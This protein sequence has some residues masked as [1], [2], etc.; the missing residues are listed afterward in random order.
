ML[1]AS[2]SVVPRP[3]TLSQTTTLHVKTMNGAAEQRTDDGG[4]PPAL[5]LAEERGFDLALRDLAEDLLLGEIGREAV[6]PAPRSAAWS[7]RPL[8]PLMTGRAI[9]RIRPRRPP[10]G[11]IHLGTT[12]PDQAFDICDLS[13]ANETSG[14]SLKY[15]AARGISTIDDG[16]SLRT[17][18]S[19][20]SSTSSSRLSNIPDNGRFAA[21]NA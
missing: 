21:R 4:R 3:S 12:L 1:G 18:P 14:W 11:S 9:R 6:L 7:C 15:V 13:R 17:S 5:R 16:A 19:K 10:R 8:S 20:S 2:A